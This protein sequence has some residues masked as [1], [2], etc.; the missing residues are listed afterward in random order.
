MNLALTLSLVA[1]TTGTDTPSTTFWDSNVR[2]TMQAGAT[3]GAEI[4][5][6]PEA[7]TVDFLLYF[8][9]RGA[10]PESIYSAGL[11]SD[12]DAVVTAPDG[13][14]VTLEYFYR[15]PGDPDLQTCDPCS[16]WRGQLTHWWP[17]GWSVSATHGATGEQLFDRLHIAAARPFKLELVPELPHPNVDATLTWW[18]AHEPGAYLTAQVVPWGSDGWYGDSADDDGHAV[19][20][21][22]FWNGASS[23]R[24][25]V[26][27]RLVDTS[28]YPTLAVSSYFQ[29]DSNRDRNR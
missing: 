4:G 17:E 27:K 24:I 12:I 29:V 26:T 1:C 8:D 21:G 15:P 13:Q 6:P 7:A 28:I 9:P 22:E 19:V 10:L 3:V 16:E 5:P 11:D 20:P 23:H 18:P 25:D 2:V 14:S